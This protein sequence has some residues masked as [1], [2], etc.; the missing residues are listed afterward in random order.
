MDNAIHLN[1]EQLEAV[2][3]TFNKVSTDLEGSY[4]ELE[5][6][7]ARLNSELSTARSARLKDLTAKEQLAA[8]LFSLM[9]SLPGGV[10]IL[11]GTGTVLNENPAAREILGRSSMGENWHHFMETGAVRGNCRNSVFTMENGRH[12]SLSNRRYGETNE[13]IVLITDVTENHILQKQL[14]RDSRLKE[15]GE[16][17]ARLAHQVRT[18]LSA[19]IL[20]LSHLDLVA[21]DDRETGRLV[22][23]IR[24]RL[25]IIDQLVQSMLSYLG[26]GQLKSE[27]FCLKSCI[28]DLGL[29]F[30]ERILA[31]N[32]K[33]EIR[34]TLDRAPYYGSRLE[35]QNALSNLVEN[36]L[37]V[38]AARPVI[39]ISLE[40][41]HNNYLVRIADNGPGI[42]D[43]SLERIFEPF[44]ST[45]IDGTGMGL[46]IVMSIVKAHN[47]GIT[48]SNT[49]SGGAC[50]E[51]SLPENID[52]YQ[53]PGGL[54]NT[55]ITA[56][57]TPAAKETNHERI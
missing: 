37:S 26:G 36:S 23:K 19:A 17:A 12:I 21:L 43:E 48:A 35:L 49:R 5:K 56:L 28:C 41:I 27:S 54:W 50:F 20:Y 18:P 34:C 22:G 6:Q 29:Q 46:A 1:L 2:F 45:R 16:M 52:E 32:G 53:Q 39:E 15:M 47:G 44:Y 10:L 38:I 25:A 9:E 4:R 8:K 24:G 51:I 31:R 11:D 55:R 42:D 3:S 14:N 33:L 40:R 13:Q 30:D 57:R 7:V